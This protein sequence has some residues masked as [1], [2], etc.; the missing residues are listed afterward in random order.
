MRNLHKFESLVLIAV[1]LLC[2][3]PSCRM[4]KEGAVQ[5]SDVTGRT[6][7]VAVFGQASADR[8][9]WS[10]RILDVPSKRAVQV[11]PQAE[12]AAY[13]APTL[14]PNGKWIAM[15]RAE[16]ETDQAD[17]F[18]I[19]CASGSERVIY[20]A[21]A[22]Q[23]VAAVSWS[24]DGEWVAFCTSQLEETITGFPP[25]RMIV[26]IISRD[27]S[28]HR[29]IADGCPVG[30]QGS[31]NLVYRALDE[32]L[33][34]VSIRAEGEDHPRQLFHWIDK[35]AHP[36]GVSPSG[37]TVAYAVEDPTSAM[38]TYLIKVRKQQEP[39]PREVASLT[40]YV[41]LGILWLGEETLIVTTASGQALAIPQEPT[42]YAINIPSRTSTMIAG[43][44]W[45]A[46]GSDFVDVHYMRLI[47]VFLRSERREAAR[48]AG[49][50]LVGGH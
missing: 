45:I 33:R 8:D 38:H 48:D 49:D 27:G 10:L 4:A 34:V 16:V 14:D 26:N 25:D 5:P 13:S 1:A 3:G 15:G 29:V 28:E 19:D 37:T 23:V 7:Q 20:S 9:A 47:T 32:T 31:T 46:G 36:A 30:W 42:V 11:W 44:G 50:R 21:G 24:P 40:A 22:N 35:E 41:I 39:H 2:A 17:L 18:I 12:V 43:P 6:S